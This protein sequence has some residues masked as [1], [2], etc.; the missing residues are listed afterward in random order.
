MEIRSQSK[1]G[2]LVPPLADIPA[3]LS[4][5]VDVMKQQWLDQLN[6]DPTSFARLEVE[7]HA[8]FRRLADQMTARLLAEA[9]IPDDRAEPGKKGAPAGPIARDALR[10][11]D[12]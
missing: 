8:H 9:V 4:Q 1:T 10:K 11:R 12:G 6:R 2:P 7:I 5:Q 3:K